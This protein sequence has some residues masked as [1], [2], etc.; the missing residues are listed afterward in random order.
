MDTSRTMI[1]VN[2]S[3]IMPTLLLCFRNINAN[4]ANKLYKTVTG[5][6]DKAP[7]WSSVPCH[8]RLKIVIFWIE[9]LLEI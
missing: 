7:S 5:V 8:S 9:L 4:M 3:G 1:D 2:Q 6:F